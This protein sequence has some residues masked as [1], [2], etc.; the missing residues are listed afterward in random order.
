MAASAAGPSFTR[1][2]D[3][4]YTECLSSDDPVLAGLRRAGF[5]E[6]DGNPY[7]RCVAGTTGLGKVLGH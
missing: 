2:G 7:V 4:L 3:H 1:D 6:A 5:T